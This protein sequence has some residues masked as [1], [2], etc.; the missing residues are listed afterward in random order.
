MK[1]NRY[2]VTI[3]SNK[4]YTSK[5]PVAKEGV[6]RVKWHCVVEMDRKSTL[7]LFVN[8]TDKIHYIY[9][10]G[11]NSNVPGFAFFKATES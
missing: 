6:M 7:T 10:N 8:L 3:K 9:R 1:G 2:N 4:S 5:K 11:G